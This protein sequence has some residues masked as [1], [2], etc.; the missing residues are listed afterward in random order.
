[1][2]ISKHET[3]KVISYQLAIHDFHLQNIIGNLHKACINLREQTPEWTA[4]LLCF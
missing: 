2:H 3:T 1:M 4:K